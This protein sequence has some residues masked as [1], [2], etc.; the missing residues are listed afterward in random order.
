MSSGGSKNNSSAAAQTV[1]PTYTSNMGASQSSGTQTFNPWEPAQ[2]SYNAIANLT[3]AQ[4]AA[5]PQWLHASDATKQAWAGGQQT[6]NAYRQA[7]QS[8]GALMPTANENYKFLSNAADVANNPYVQGM[9]ASNMQQANQNLQRN[10]LPAI[11]SGAQQVGAMG[12]SRMGMAQ[13]QAIGDTSTGLA[14]TN[15]NMMMN[16]YGQGLGAQQYALGQ[17]GA[18]QSAY[19]AK[20]QALGQAA[21]TLGAIGQSQEGY[22]QNQL[23]APWQQI[24]NLG[25]GLQYTNP[26]GTLS[27]TSK[28]TQ[29]ANSAPQ[30]Y[31]DPQTMGV[32]NQAQAPASYY[33]G[34]SGWPYY[35]GQSGSVGALQQAYNPY[36]GWAQA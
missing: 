33:G 4:A 12:S 10:L 35:G 14:N 7:A 23:N 30:G 24:Q 17:T 9:M 25:A 13:G 15:A 29:V 3:N 21:Q 1:T 34:Q 18:L 8:M 11:Q 16:A 31:Y 26:L 19:G 27:N 22:T 36:Q 6:A 20:A 2:P 32:A 28:G 5:G